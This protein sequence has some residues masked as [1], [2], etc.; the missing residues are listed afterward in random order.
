MNQPVAV[1]K[2]QNRKLYLKASSRYTTLAELAETIKSGQDIVVT[3][4][5]TGLDVTAEVIGDVFH[6]TYNPPAGDMLA[7]L[8][9]VEGT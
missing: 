4:K 2:Y 5:V 1:V 7:A 9:G 3:S 8:R 6:A